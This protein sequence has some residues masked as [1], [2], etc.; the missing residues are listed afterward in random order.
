MLE[1]V[2]EPIEVEVDFLSKRVWPR[3]LFWSGRVYELQRPTLIHSQRQ[4]QEKI[5]YFSVSDGVNFFR[6]AFY[7][8][9]LQW[10]LEEIYNDS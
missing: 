7:T 5:Y 10:R 2:N 8:D 9:N 3:K 6:L 4:G 1:K